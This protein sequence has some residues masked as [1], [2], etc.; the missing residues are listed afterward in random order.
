VSLFSLP[1]SRRFRGGDFQ[2][3]SIPMSIAATPPP[4]YYAAIFSSIRTADDHAAYEATGEAMAALAMQQ[5]GFLGF[6]FGADTPERF[7]VFVSYWRSDED[8]RAWKQVAQHLK[9]QERG[10]SHWYAAY[11]IRIA[12]V[13]RDY[14]KDGG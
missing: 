12:R 10:R 5:P 4:P 2:I 11:R 3:G 9:A 13:E 8:I 14:G 1:S 7:S 6:E